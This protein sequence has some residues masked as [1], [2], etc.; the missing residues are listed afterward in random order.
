MLKVWMVFVLALGFT[1]CDEDDLANLVKGDP[2]AIPVG[3][4]TSDCKVEGTDSYQDAVEIISQ[5][6]IVITTT[7]YL[8]STD[9][10]G[11]G[12]AQPADMVEISVS[13]FSF[14]NQIAYF[15]TVGENLFTAY[16]I[17]DGVIYFSES[18]ADVNED[19]VA[20]SFSEFVKDPKTN[21]E[22]VLTP[23]SF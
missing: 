21:A 1:A 14:A 11:S 12:T 17:E 20:S 4:Y 2:I 22:T 7:D 9:C 10:S 5:T 3:N 23:P 15:Q 8:A 13:D 18:K 16:F 19:N 6:E